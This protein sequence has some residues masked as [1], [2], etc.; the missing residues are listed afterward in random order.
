MAV[1]ALPTITGDREEKDSVRQRDAADQTHR[2]WWRE[3]LSGGDGIEDDGGGERSEMAARCRLRLAS[4]SVSCCSASASIRTGSACAS[5]LRSRR[6]SP[7]SYWR[8]VA[9]SLS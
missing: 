4:V 1:Q 2:I 6:L 8:R 7:L 3:R 5:C 9:C